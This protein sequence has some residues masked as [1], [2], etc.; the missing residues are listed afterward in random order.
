MTAEHGREKAEEWLAICQDFADDLLRDSGEEAVEAFWTRLRETFDH[1]SRLES[2]RK[3]IAD[4]EAVS[5]EFGIGCWA[6]I[7]TPYA[8][9]RAGTPTPFGKAVI[10]GI[11][12][13]RGS[14][15]PG[16]KMIQ[17]AF[18]RAVREVGL[19]APAYHL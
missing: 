19:P 3:Q 7:L 11:V 8:M 17:T 10:Q 13:L 4:A 18:D 2:V 1:Q 15:E 9:D 16:P 5:G 12:E 6:S 14:A